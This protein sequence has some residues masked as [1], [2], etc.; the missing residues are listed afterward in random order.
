MLHLIIIYA[1]EVDSNR[2][3]LKAVYTTVMMHSLLTEH[4]A[5]LRL[6]I[7]HSF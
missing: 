2:K 4:M 1:M 3:F 7:L 5:L 6:K